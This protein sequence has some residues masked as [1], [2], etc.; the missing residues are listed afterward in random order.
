M[1]P[2]E[3]LNANPNM[4]FDFSESY[5]NSDLDVSRVELGLRFSYEVNELLAFWGRYR[6]LDYEDDAPYLCD[7]SGEIS[8]YSLGLAWTF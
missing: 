1:V 2:A 6:W 5:L 3:F 8:L 7:T 4:S